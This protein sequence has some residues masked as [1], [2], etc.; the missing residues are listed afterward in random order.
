MFMWGDVV[1][2]FLQNTSRFLAVG[3]LALVSVVG[4]AE[5]KPASAVILDFETLQAGGTGFAFPGSSYEEDGF[6]L[7]APGVDGF[8]SPRT[9]SSLYAGSTSLV[10]NNVLNGFAALTKTGGGA[11]DVLSIDLAELRDGQ[12]GPGQVTFTGEKV[13]GLT[14]NISFTLDGGENDFETF[15]FTSFFTDLTSLT[16]DQG[17]SFHHQ[18]DNINVS[19]SISAVPLPAALPLYGAGVAFLGFIGWRKRKRQS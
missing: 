1:K 8:V 14:Q 10:I 17:F 11:F 3:A 12:Q 7:T 15:F 16:W 6:T 4:I 2:R 19:A 5:M 18:F 13:G 9:G